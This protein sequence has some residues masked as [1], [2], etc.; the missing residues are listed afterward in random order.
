MYRECSKFGVPVT[1]DENIPTEN[2]EKLIGEYLY[3]QKLPRE[4][5]IADM[6]PEQ[7]RIMERRGII[8]RIKSAIENIVDMFEW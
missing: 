1:K 6:L 4:Q 2:L 7:P 5:D 8:N 3:T